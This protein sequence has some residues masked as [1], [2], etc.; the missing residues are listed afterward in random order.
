MKGGESEW[1]LT[2]AAK[3]EILTKIFSFPLSVSFEGPVVIDGGEGGNTSKKIL[4]TL[5]FPRTILLKFSS[6]NAA[7]ASATGKGFWNGI[8]EVT[9]ISISPIVS[10]TSKKTSRTRAISVTSQG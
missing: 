8:C 6:N 5:T 9:T 7:G 3:D 4:S 10:F 2:C 1:L